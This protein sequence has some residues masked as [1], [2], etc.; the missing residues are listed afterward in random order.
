M[1][2]KIPKLLYKWV[3]GQR[4]GFCA[5]NSAFLTKVRILCSEFGKF[6]GKDLV[7]WILVFLCCSLQCPGSQNYIVKAQSVQLRWWPHQRTAHWVF[8]HHFLFRCMTKLP[9]YSELFA[10]GF[11]NR[12]I[13]EIVPWVQIMNGIA[14]KKR[15]LSH[16]E[17][18]VKGGISKDPLIIY[19]SGLK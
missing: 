19:C 7:F 14:K 15:K 12:S 9:L 18:I 8:P 3:W 5:L 11:S 16:C 6:S 13:S 2:H 1:Y 10:L 4:W 17:A